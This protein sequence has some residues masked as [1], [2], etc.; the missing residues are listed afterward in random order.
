LGT[1]WEQFTTIPKAFATSPGFK[2]T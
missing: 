1:A 2:F